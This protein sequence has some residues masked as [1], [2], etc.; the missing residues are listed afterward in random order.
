[1]R[2]QVPRRRRRA[3]RA[4]AA[5]MILHGDTFWI[6]PYFFSCF[7]ALRE[8]GLAFDVVPVALERGEQRETSYRERSLTGRVPVLDHDGFVLAESS[9]IVD[10]L[11]EAFPDAPRA[12]PRGVRERSRARQIMAWIRSDLMPIREERSTTTMFYARATAPL[13]PAAERSRE[14]LVF[15][16]SRLLPTSGKY[17]FGDF[18]VADADLAF[19]L[20]R[21][22]LNGDPVPDDVAAWA[23][24]VWERPSV[25][26]FVE[27]PRAPYV[28]YTY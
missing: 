13:S 1:M 22:I 27:R 14:R 17:L 25:R 11:D 19:M 24:G 26:E 3:F 18:S 21:L 15:V 23:K 9:A 8:K 2:N 10:Y 12:L 28:P 5:S 16:A 4:I 7:V 20:H 6:S